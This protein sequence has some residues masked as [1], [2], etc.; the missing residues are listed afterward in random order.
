MLFKICNWLSPVKVRFGRAKHGRRTG[1][2]GGSIA[3]VQWGHFID[4]LLGYI[5]V[6]AHSNWT[7]LKYISGEYMPPEGK[8]ATTD[9]FITSACLNR[10]APIPLVHIP[11][12]ENVNQ[13]ANGDTQKSRQHC[14]STWT[15][16]INR[17]LSYIYVPC[18]TVS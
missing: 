14:K 17:P 8:R 1:E 11:S 13:M 12:S 10:Y 15:N 7:T 3:Y 18:L 5:A 4:M 2:T 9:K 16:R 6:S